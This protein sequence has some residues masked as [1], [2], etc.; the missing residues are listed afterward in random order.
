MLQFQSYLGA[1]IALVK[2]ITK[3][4]LCALLLRRYAHTAVL[5][6][7]KQ[8]VEQKLPSVAVQTVLLLLCQY[9]MQIR[10]KTEGLTLTVIPYTLNTILKW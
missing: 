10:K 9:N 1:L 4:A 3:I 5:V 2:F 7:V 8:T 6:S